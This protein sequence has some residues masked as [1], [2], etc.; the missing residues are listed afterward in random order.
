MALIAMDGAEF[1]R[2]AAE[3]VITRAGG[4]LTRAQMHAAF[5]VFLEGVVD[6]HQEL[7]G[8]P[9]TA[10]EQAAHD[11]FTAR[12]AELDALATQTTRSDH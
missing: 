8:E 9:A 4:S 12:L 11:A 7:R 1:G 10:F 6:L 2:L 5:L 3:T